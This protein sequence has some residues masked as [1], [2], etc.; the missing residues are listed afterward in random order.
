MKDHFKD[1]D[2]LCGAFMALRDRDECRRFLI[3]LCTVGELKALSQRLEVAS[4]L[5]DA[6]TYEDI[7]AQTKA[8]TATISRVKKYLCHGMDGYR[9]VLRR[10]AEVRP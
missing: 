4:L 10:L 5:A 9:L 7:T 1:V 3:D 2:R 8:S 6:A